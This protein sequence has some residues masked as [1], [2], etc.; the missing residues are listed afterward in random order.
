[1]Q[2]G[3]F[4]RAVHYARHLAFLPQAPH[5]D[6]EYL[7]IVL[8][9]LCRFPTLAEARGLLRFS[10]SEDFGQ[11]LRRFPGFH[12]NRLFDTWQTLLSFKDRVLWP[13]GVYTGLGGVPLGWAY[14]MYRLV[15]KQRF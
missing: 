11:G 5:E 10:H 7:M 12:T 6:R 15:M 4:D 3:I 2:A 9:R 13:E 8:D 1:L 14:N